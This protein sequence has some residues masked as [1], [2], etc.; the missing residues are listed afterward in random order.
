MGDGTNVTTPG[1]R[2]LRALAHPTRLRLLGLLRSD[3]PATAT[4][5]A[6][7]LAI[8]SGQTSYHLRQLAQ[9]GFIEDDPS[10]T[11][12]GRERWWRAAHTSTSYGDEGPH[13]T[14]DVDD[15]AVRDAVGAFLQAVAIVH[16]EQVQRAV[17]ERDLLPDQWRAVSVLADWQLRLTPRRAAALVAALEAV[18]EETEP[19][20]DGDGAADV[21]VQLAAFPRPGVLTDR[22]PAW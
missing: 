4:A 13:G 21:V 8:N 10:A 2:A 7:R 5:L 20:D 15:P 3:G 14:A 16:G 9:H 11:G 19:D 12:V 6:A 18:V 1:P 17:E 22:G